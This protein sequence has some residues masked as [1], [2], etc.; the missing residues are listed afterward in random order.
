MH[1]YYHAYALHFKYYNSRRGD[2]YPVKRTT[3]A[4]IPVAAFTYSFHFYV[5]YIYQAKENISMKPACRRRISNPRKRM[6]SSI[7]FEAA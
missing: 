1:A 6:K 2:T 3:T 5:T 7:C 4:R